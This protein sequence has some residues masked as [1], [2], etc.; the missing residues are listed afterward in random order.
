M[1]AERVGPPGF[2]NIRAI[3]PC[4]AGAPKLGKPGRGRPPGSKNRHPALRI[5]GGKLAAYWANADSLLFFQQLGVREVPTRGRA[6][7][8]GDSLAA[9]PDPGPG[10]G[11]WMRPSIPGRPRWRRRPA[12][13]ARRQV[14]SRG[15]ASR[16]EPTPA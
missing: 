5:A 2:R 10:P 12:W 16:S 15:T 4:P 11:G 6:V 9:R 13:S 7:I 8:R 14:L 3:M 1:R